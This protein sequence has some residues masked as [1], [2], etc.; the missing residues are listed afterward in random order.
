[1]QET[2]NNT[3]STLIYINNF[4]KSIFEKLVNERIDEIVQFINIQ[5]IIKYADELMKMQ[6]R[7]KVEIYMTHRQNT[8]EALE[9]IKMLKTC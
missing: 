8:S 3:K 5:D 1:M 6:K 4:D 2:Y 7:V 9:N